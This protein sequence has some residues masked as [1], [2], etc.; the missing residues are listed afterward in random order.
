MMDIQIVAIGFV[1]MLALL[2]FSLPV[3]AVMTITGV[4]GG[5]LLYGMPLVDSMGSVI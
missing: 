3:A 5:F 1:V 2:R 4:V